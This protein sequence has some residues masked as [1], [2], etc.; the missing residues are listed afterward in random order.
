MLRSTATEDGA[1]EGVMQG[2]RIGAAAIQK[3]HGIF[4]SRHLGRVF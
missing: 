1:K 2:N 3:A 4:S